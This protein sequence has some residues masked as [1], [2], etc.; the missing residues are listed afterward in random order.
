MP[1][2]AP[3]VQLEAAMVRVL[4]QGL[5]GAAAAVLLDFIAAFHSLDHA[6]LWEISFKLG[7]TWFVVRATRRCAYSGKRHWLP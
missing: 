2:L 6:F 5:R 4:A 3:V 1:I 7:L